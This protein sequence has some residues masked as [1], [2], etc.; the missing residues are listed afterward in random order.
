MF[1]TKPQ[2]HFKQT[3][4]EN[5]YRKINNH[6]TPSPTH[7]KFHRKYNKNAVA[8]NVAKIKNKCFFKKIKV[9]QPNLKNIYK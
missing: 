5:S 1:T 8:T 6:M 9:I 7:N 2:Q 4:K 3:K